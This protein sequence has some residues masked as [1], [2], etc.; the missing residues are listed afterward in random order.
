MEHWVFNA[1]DMEEW[2]ELEQMVSGF[3][4]ARAQA[5]V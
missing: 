4:K 2:S 5:N 1:I 3:W